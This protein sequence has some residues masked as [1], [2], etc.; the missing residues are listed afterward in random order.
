M[1]IAASRRSWLPRVG[2][3]LLVLASSGHRFANE[4]V[5]DDDAVIVRGALIHDPANLPAIWTRHTM[6][7][8]A[9]DR[10][11]QEVDTYRPVPLT[12]F[13]F[14]AMVSGRDPW[15]YHLTSLLLHLACVLLLH[16]LLSHLVGGAGALYGAAFFAVFPWGVE[17]HVWI[18]GRSDPLSLV[19]L[20]LV[21]HALARSRTLVALPL[22]ALALLSKET[23]LMV[24][25]ALWLMP[26]PD[27]RGTSAGS[28][29]VW[30]E[31]DLLLR[32]AAVLAAGAG[33]Y[34]VMRL[35]AL[36]GVR[37]SSPGRAMDALERLPLVLG[38]GLRSLFLPELPYLQSLVDELTPSVGAMALGGLATTAFVVGALVSRETRPL[39]LVG[40]SWTLLPLVPVSLIATMLWPG[41]GRY[42]YT[43]AAGL[44]L[45]LAMVAARLQARLAGPRRQL[46]RVVLGVH[47]GL[48]S[49]LSIAYTLQF[50]TSEELYATSAELAPEIDM[51]VGFLGMNLRR[52]GDFVRAVPLLERAIELDPDR[53]RYWQHLA[54]SLLAMGE[55]DAARS[56]SAEGIARFEGDP[57]TFG[58]HWVAVQ[59]LPHRDPAAAIH[60]LVRCVELY[61][62]FPDCRRALAGLLAPSAPDHAANRAAWE[63]ELGRRTEARR[64]GLERALAQEETARD[65]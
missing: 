25:P 21:A 45:L 20:L 53:I 36:E 48:L 54:S 15:M 22:W 2:L 59:S 49:L 55:R 64:A 40:V 17:A 28:R 1:G 37:V 39:A 13:V 62:A 43:P 33:I 63:V 46:V 10:G 47:I 6:A 44:S 5:L 56:V 19:F 41:W 27:A 16:A 60:H 18:N 23:A 9:A 38:H 29:Y 30:P 52:E 7:A 57:R 26:I 58:L 34:L 35:V 24:A 12:S 42:L 11:Y 4:F 8:S 50:R 14:D 61:P 31:R 3:V 32:R 65:E 51:G